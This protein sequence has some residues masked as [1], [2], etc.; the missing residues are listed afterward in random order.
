MFAKIQKYIN[1]CFILL[2][3]QF[4]AFP[5]TPK[6][7]TV[8]D[9]E[10]I[11]AG[12]TRALIVGISKYQYIDSLQYADRDAQV[13][14]D[15][16]RNNSFWGIDKD[17]VTLLVNDKAKNGDMITQL[18]RIAQVSKPGDNLLFYFSGHGDVETLTQF[19]NG[20]LLAYDTY[21][22]NYIAGALPISF[23]KELFVT[24]LNK[25]VKILLVTDAC[26]SGKLAGGMKGAE[27]AA[28]AISNMWKNEIKILS[29]QPGQLSFEGTKWGNG[30]GVFSYY[31][32]NGLNGEADANK[33]S[34]ITLSELEMYVGSNVARETGNKQQPIFEGPN[35][36]STI[37]AKIKPAVAKSN[38]K[39]GGNSFTRLSKKIRIPEDS[40]FY[41][42]REMNS[43]IKEKR[44]SL[45]I[46]NSATALY[47]KLKTCTKDSGFIIQA[48]S[49]LLAALMNNAQEIVNNSFIGK[50][51]V[52][53]EQFED[54]IDL[55][56]QVLKNN[57]LKLPYD[58]YL[59][60][61]K[62]Y[63]FVQGKALWFNE[64][65]KQVPADK[66][67]LIIDSAINEEPDAAY[68]L[69]AK[70]F[71]EMRKN[72]WTKA[73]Q[74]LE[75]AVGK[76]P[77]W[78]IPKYQ[79]GICYANKK[80]H[81]KALEYYEQVLQKDTLYKT[82]EC[83]KCIL[84]NMA[85]YAVELKQNRRALNYLFKSIDLFPDYS[86][87]YD[88]VYDY[89]I[90][91]KDTATATAF[92]HRLKKY[93]D[94]ASMRLM[95]IRFEKEFYRTALSVK[96]LDSVILLLKDDIDSADYFYTLGMYY[97]E[98]ADTDSAIYLYNKA[99]ELD[100]TESFYLFALI[101]EL[102]EN[103]DNDEIQRLLFTRINNYEGD[104]KAE[105]Q[106]E[107]VTSLI[108]TDNYKEAFVVCKELKETGFYKCNDL[109][110]YK[111]VFGKL[112]EYQEYMKNCKDKQE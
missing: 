9:K 111:K 45:T 24:L 104:D 27:F 80:N 35:K 47:K 60:N 15:Y 3:L 51:L 105:L 22:N 52:P 6:G 49:E 109:R 7:I 107:L 12:K 56:D 85:E 18:A 4:S 98:E 14:A 84:L 40:C 2:V 41:Y 21:S 76:S 1:C 53:E 13:F 23:L 30:R 8:E 65:K 66:L 97:K 28:S 75:V 59:K 69:S 82:F 79:L 58:Q 72:N 43:A 73:I 100:S 89:A 94:T 67:G 10:S 70:A 32:I 90:E 42:Y 29:S 33:D 16:L 57:D 62:R 106:Y 31:L 71:V 39:N 37:I 86:S 20:Y 54:G 83:T 26:R 11:A 110:K 91:K 102:K 25:D 93:G 61:L 81:A 64:T 68:L 88:I 95:R 99:V 19:N 103:D 46:S 74:L 108:E 96:S 77:G 87:P 50:N 44:F 48:N 101:K 36:Y 112:P 38:L 34:S 78:L 17:D 92:I 63:L 55:I 5:Q